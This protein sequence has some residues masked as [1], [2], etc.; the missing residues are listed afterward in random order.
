MNCMCQ[1]ISELEGNEALEFI[2]DHL[3]TIFVD[4]EIWQS[5]YECPITHIYWLKDY[6]DSEYHGGGSPRLRKISA[7]PK[8]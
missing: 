7:G 2:G 3:Q 4:S 5:L 1:A 8:V 6:P